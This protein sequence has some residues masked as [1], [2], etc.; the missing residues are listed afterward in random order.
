MC[1]DS[2]ELLNQCFWSGCQGPLFPYQSVGDLDTEGCPDGYKSVASRYDT[3]S[4]DWCSLEFS[5]PLHDRFKQGLCCPKSKGF[6]NC[7]WTSD[8]LGG[9]DGGTTLYDPARA[10]QPSQCKKTQTKLAEAYEPPL[11]PHFVRCGDGHCTVGDKCSAY[12]ILPEF[13]PQFYLCCDPPSEY[14]EK[15]PVP[16]SW[17]WES[18]YDDDDDDVA[19]SF[20]GNEGNNNEETSDETVEED[21]SGK[22]MPFLVQVYFD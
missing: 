16:P 22:P 12:P 5:S 9:E 1:C 17:L 19:W 13:D 15:W 4:G 10:C 14:N 20:A 21:P 11:N 2:T 3:N 18:A 6:D 7:Q 8:S